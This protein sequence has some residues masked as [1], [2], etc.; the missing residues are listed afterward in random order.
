[1]CHTLQLIDFVTMISQIDRKFSLKISVE[2]RKFLKCQKTGKPGDF[3][4]H[5]LLK[6]TRF[7]VFRTLPYV[8]MCVYVLLPL[9]H[10]SRSTSSLEQRVPVRVVAAHACTTN[11]ITRTRHICTTLHTV[12]YY[13]RFHLPRAYS[14]F[15]LLSY[16]QTTRL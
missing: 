13:K 1:M 11:T 4:H 7:S 9:M 14:F 8:Y 10:P 5:A 12:L 15:F 6:P 16:F 2:I 3:S